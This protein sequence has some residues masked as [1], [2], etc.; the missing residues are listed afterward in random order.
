[1]KPK[2]KTYRLADSSKVIYVSNF[3]TKKE[4]QELY[5]ELK[6][7]IPWTQGVY[8]MFGKPIKT[9]RMLYA[10]KDKDVDITGSYTVTNSVEWTPLAKKLKEKVEKQTGKTFTYA[11]LNWYRDGNDYIGYH[12]DSE[13]KDGDIIASISLGAKRKFVFRHKDYKTRKNIKTKHEFMLEDGSL[14]VMDENAGKKKWKHTLPKMKDVG[15]RINI[16]F[17]PN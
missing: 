5:N 13:I 1:M 8:M 12:T 4:S 17:R 10:V 2:T 14:I 3:L 7:S 16:T 15:S 6:N 9:P 11:Q